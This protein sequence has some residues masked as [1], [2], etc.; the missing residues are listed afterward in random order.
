MSCCEVTGLHFGLNGK[1][2]ENCL[3]QCLIKRIADCLVFSGFFD[4]DDDDDDPFF[5]GSCRLWET[6]FLVSKN[7]VHKDD[8]D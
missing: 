3:F 6:H 8:G 1:R 4:D 2:E 5:G 7:V